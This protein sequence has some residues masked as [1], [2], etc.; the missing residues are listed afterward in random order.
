MHK[1]EFSKSPVI[2]DV[3]TAHIRGEQVALLYNSIPSA[4][5]IT[6][7]NGVILSLVQWSYVNQTL[8]IIWITLIAVISTA[9]LL[10]YQRYLKA[11]P[12]SLEVAPWARWFH[13]SLIL[14][15]CIWGSSAYLLFPSEDAVR[16]VFLAFVLAGMT[17]GAITTLSA[18]LY[19]VLAFIFTSLVP[20]IVRLL[21]IN[22]PVSLPM[23]VLVVLFLIMMCVTAWRSH[24]AVSE[25]LS[26]RYKFRRTEE[27]LRLAASTFETHEGILVSNRQGIILRANDAVT[28]ITGYSN[29]E[30]VGQSVKILRDTESNRE[31]YRKIGRTLIKTG[32]WVGELM[33]RHESGKLY[34]CWITVAE[35]KN[36]NGEVTHY[37]THFQDITE[38][39]QAEAHIEFQAHYDELT[40]LPNR[41]L[42]LE[43]LQQEVS[44]AKRHLQIGAVL[45]IDLDR[46]KTINDSL[47]HAVGDALL[48]DVAHRLRTCLRVEDTAARL[49]GDEFVVLLPEL[50]DNVRKAVRSA[51]SAAEKI[52]GALSEPYTIEGQSLHTTPSTGITLYPVNAGS[53]EEL[54]NQADIAMYRAKEQGRNAFQFFS[55]SMQTAANER[56]A[57]ENDLRAAIWGD[58][59]TL[60][61]QPQVDASGVIVGA[62]AL[63]R[64][65]Q[66][67]RGIVSPANFIP[68]A[69]ETG[70]IIPIGAWVL[71]A[72]CT[73]IK[74]CQEMAT[75]NSKV[76]TPH[77]AVNVSPRQFRQQGFVNVVT[78]TLEQTGADPRYL[79]LE[80]TEGMLI[81]DIED[82]ATKMQALS[83]MGVRL[84]I[85]DF[86][87]GYSSLSYLKRLPLDVLKIDQ[88][89]VQDATYDSSDATIVEAIISMARHL[90]LQVIAEGVESQEELTMLQAMGCSLY[91]GFLF[92]TPMSMDE[93]L[94]RLQQQGHIQGYKAGTPSS[95]QPLSTIAR[96]FNSAFQSSQDSA[97]SP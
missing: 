19:A 28:G 88:S 80:L 4:V 36:E 9:R 60:N 74:L 8:A 92:F 51:Q 56:L 90:E 48:K 23:G 15:G 24:R 83:K 72:V 1:Y 41:R 82:T 16:Q 14:A 18:D 43:R 34:P 17:A 86:G 5:A 97:N 68:I 10:M 93:L 27:D 20:F 85:D 79:E 76:S 11:K 64:W 73:Q 2:I 40:A 65:Q 89:F 37:V 59:L 26:M 78:Q 75:T 87:T 21:S 25:F 62:E 39:K 70:L 30:L 58:E 35:V 49:G 38:R 33:N 96:S 13:I 94:Q 12:A 22:S 53:G 45:F 55:P 66:P 42:F 32:R 31:F 50:G 67:Q 6:I 3:D 69:E 71:H 81:D 63:L 54:L 44:R 57:L 61:Y 77:F 29:N 95:A 91:Q 47:G 52:Q 46:F 84:S 7:I